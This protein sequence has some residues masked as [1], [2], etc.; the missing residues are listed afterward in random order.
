[1]AGAML[2]LCEA[3]YLTCLINHNLQ[4]WNLGQWWSLSWWSGCFRH[5][6]SAVRISKLAKF[7]PSIVEN[8]KDENKE[9]EAGNCPSFK[10]KFKSSR[11][12]SWGKLEVFNPFHRGFGAG[13]SIS[14]S[15]THNIH[16]GWVAMDLQEPV[17]GQS[18]NGES[19]LKIGSITIKPGLLRFLYLIL[20]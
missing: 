6:R 9:K 1:M 11:S 12:P 5:Q 10:T 18:C 7:Y 2:I 13:N 14:G 15:K 20:Q 19:Y 16:D 17:V 4:N 3:F 8:R